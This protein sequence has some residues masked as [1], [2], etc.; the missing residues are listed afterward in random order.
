M[1]DLF[2]EV[3]EQLRS[4]RY[5]SLFRRLA[6]WVTGVLAV[7]LLGYFGFWGFKAWQ[8]RNLATAAG[9]YQ[10]GVDALSQGDVAGAQSSFQASEKAGAPGY[11]TLALMQQAA[12]AIADGKT[13]DAAKLY[14]QA[15]AAAPNQIFGDLARLRAAQALLDTAP[16][17]QLQT[18]LTPLTDAK[19]PF[20]PYAKEALAMAELL[21]GRTAAA[22]ARPH[23]ALAELRR[24]GGHAPARPARHRGDRRRRGAQRHCSGE[25]RRHNAAVTADDSRA[26]VHG[27]ACSGRGAFISSRSRS[28]TPRRHARVIAAIVDRL[29][30]ARRML[31]DPL[32]VPA[33]CEAG[34]RP[35]PGERISLLELSDQLKV[36]DSLKGQDFFLPPPQPQAD[37]PLAGGTLEQ[38]VENVD[39]APDFRLAWRRNF[40]A[41]SDRTTQFVMAP[42]VVA[43]GKIFVMDADA[44][45]SAHDARTGA[46]GLAHRPAA[47]APSRTSSERDAFGG[48]LAYADGKL[49][50]AS[51]YRLVAAAR[52]RH[53]PGRLAH[54][55]RRADAR[56]ADRRRRPRLSPSTSNDELLTFDADHRHAGLDLPGADRAG[57]DPGGLQPGGLQ[58]HPGRLVRL[59]RAGGAAE[60]TTA[61]SCGTC[62]CRA[63]PAP[64]RSPRSATSPGGR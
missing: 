29:A 32:A 58:R 48:G 50:V 36:S 56:R 51:G 20:A 33:A 25:G 10:K 59:G 21:A 37:W 8:D 30:G 24:A 2:D 9:A 7:V 53:R 46:P 14:D 63:P 64:T 22:Q 42:P 12:L 28:M 62:R 47:P 11:K 61:T 4:E 19:R 43:A 15:A 13:A 31:V 39:A 40:G 1:V 27:R 16:F 57:A 35:P 52:R 17:A 23:R 45:V 38:S 60:P 34:R 55:H 44:G 49:Y 26:A 54:A 18:R 41:K 3:D 5:V 6:P